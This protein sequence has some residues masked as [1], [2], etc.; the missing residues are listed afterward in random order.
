MRKRSKSVRGNK[1]TKS[2]RRQASGKNRPGKDASSNVLLQT[3]YC[4][5]EKAILLGVVAFDM[6]AVGLIVPL[7]TP[8]LRKLGASASQ[9]GFL[10]S[11][12]GSVQMFS[13]PLLGW[14]SD[15]V[16]RRDVLFICILAGAFG[17]GLLGIAHSLRMVLVSRVIVG[18]ARQTQTITKAWLSDLSTKE[19]RLQ[20]LSWFSATVSIGFMLGPTVGGKLAK[21]YGSYHVPFTVA[22]ILFLLNSFLVRVVLPRKLL[23]SSSQRAVIPTEHVPSKTT[24]RIFLGQFASLEPAL[25]NLLLIRLLLA[26]GV[27]LGRNNLFNL[28]EYK[29]TL[30]VEEKGELI[31]F[32]A[33]VSVLSQL[34]IIAP[35]SRNCG[36]QPKYMLLL[37]SFLTSVGFVA[38]A[39]SSAKVTFML[40][41]GFVAVCSSAVRVS[42][43][44]LLTQAAGKDAYG[45]VLGVAGSVSSLCRAIAPLI[46]GILIDIYDNAALPTLLASCFCLG[47]TL[48]GLVLI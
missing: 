21:R 35:L 16:S 30:D 40:C 17:Y 7:L 8:F 19:T 6:F 12:Y 45:E 28:L 47:V 25:R 23:D 4:S 24:P 26:A 15:R 43:S 38:L 29:Q 31:S 13:A 10:S 46:G 36:F 48:F 20:D 9:I 27:M 33:V 42:M 41:L 22:F 34:L 14:I 1:T 18:V 44:T 11:V 32:F 37:F 5:G 2:K 3:R 39:Y